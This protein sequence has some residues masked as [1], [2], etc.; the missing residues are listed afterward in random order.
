MFVRR[1]GCR[2]Q[3]VRAYRSANGNPTNQSLGVV[4]VFDQKIKTEIAKQ[5]SS[6]DQRWLMGEISKERSRC[7]AES[8]E[9]LEKLATCASDITDDQLMGDKIY[10]ALVR[11]AGLCPSA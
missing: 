4:G 11:L 1:R 9:I 5:L 10:G 2:L 7:L 8:R 6:V 3:V